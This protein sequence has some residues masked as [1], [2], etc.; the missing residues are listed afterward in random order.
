FSSRSAVL[1]SPVM[2][3]STEI[4]RTGRSRIVSLSRLNT[5]RKCL[6]R[7]PAPPLNST[8]FPENRWASSPIPW[9]IASVSRRTMKCSGIRRNLLLFQLGRWNGLQIIVRPAGL[10]LDIFEV[11]VGEDN[12]HVGLI[13]MQIA[14]GNN[15]DVRAGGELVLLQGAV[16]DGERDFSRP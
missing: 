1:G 11:F 16:I 10:L 14:L 3:L 12:E 15:R 7:K 13:F 6:P 9:T 4:T 2:K 5:R 8:V